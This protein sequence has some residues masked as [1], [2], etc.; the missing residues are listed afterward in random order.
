MSPADGD[1]SRPG[2]AGRP[3]D[4]RRTGSAAGPGTGG[5]ASGPGAATAGAGAADRLSRLLAMVPWLLERQGVA[6]EEAARH[7]DVT[8][9]QL[10]A[11]LE[12][13]FVCGAPGHMPDDLIEADWESG[14]VYLGNADAIARPLRLGQDEALA[15]IVGLRT[16]ADL[17]GVE[18][19]A[20]L[21][22]ALSKLS[23][24]AGD[25]AAAAGSV[26][27][28][29]AAGADTEV[30]AVVRGALA[31]RRRLHLRYLTA[32]RDETTERDVD[33]V[34]LDSV[35]GRF[36][37]QAWCHRAQGVRRF[38]LD[39]VLAADELDEDGTP[40]AD[41]VARDLD[42]NLLA[43]GED[44]PLVVLDLAPS[45]RWVA[46][47]FPVESVEPRP[48]APGRRA[49]RSDDGDGGLRV[50][51]RVADGA[52]LRRLVLRLGGA[53]VVVA[54]PALAGEVAAAARAALAA[55]QD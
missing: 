7:F 4:G 42:D 41:A 1:G 50:R 31:R 45:A 48:A 16:L 6:L 36:Y 28:D 46:E 47:S 22:S 2:S 19:S 17:R 40:P 13:L 32:T 39:R 10:V 30:L 54:P 55:A 51:L 12:L 8:T 35:D 44:L 34:S 5:R 11:D 37:L 33:P 20:V 43:P 3:G 18:D 14:R 49:A 15:L 53:A 38:R 21:E 29:L 26:Q 27:L 25:A 9:D 23:E 24:A 52:W